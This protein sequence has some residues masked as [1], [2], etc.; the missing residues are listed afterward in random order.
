MEA[1]R[2]MVEAD[3]DRVVSLND[4]EVQQTSLMDRGQLAALHCMSSYAKVAELD[5]EVGAFL[6]A[7]RADA[8]YANANFQWFVSRFPDFLYVDRIV[9]G[10]SYSGRGI[11]RTLYD[12]MFAFAR[13]AG[14]RRIACEYNVEPPNPASR[15]FH[16]GFGFREC[17]RQHVAGGAKLVSLQVAE[18]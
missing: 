13:S 14:I 11:G 2:D 7:L 3:F 17:G 4:A 18:T 10:A 15:A 5:G 16:A 1:F 9:V 6:L 8:P 12:Q